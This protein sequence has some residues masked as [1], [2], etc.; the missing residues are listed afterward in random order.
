MK[1]IIGISVAVLAL[2][3]PSAV[4]QSAQSPSTPSDSEIRAIL[5]D[6]ID[7]QHAN[8]GIVVGIIGPTGRRVIAYG[9]MAK[10]DKRSPDGSTVF[11]I[12]S[13]TKV[14]TSLLLA[15]MAQ[16]GE[17][18]LA[19][20]VAK[21]L[22]V[23]VKAPE[24]AGKQI[25][26]QDLATHT[27]GLPKNPSNMPEKDPANPFADYSLDQLYQFLTTYQLTREIGVQYEYSSLGSGLL[28]NALARRAGMSY[29][30][31]LQARICAPLG[32]NDTRITLTPEMESRMAA[33]YNYKLKPVEKNWDMPALAGAGALR[34]TANDLLTFLAANLG[35]TKTSLAP[36]MA[37]MLLVRRH[38]GTPEMDSLLGWH[39]LKLNGREFIWHDGAT[40]GYTSFIGFDPVAGNGV[41]VLSNTQSTGGVLDIGEHLLNPDIPLHQQPKVIAV[42]PK[43][44]EGFVGSYRLSSN[45]TLT[46]TSDK[47]HL[48]LQ[49]AGL[50]KFEMAPVS[51][52]EY[53]LMGIDAHVT[54]GDEIQG[55]AGSATLHQIGISREAKRIE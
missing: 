51:S 35:N 5:I 30:K 23:G 7:T 8:V 32:M 12:G 54:F 6:R 24:Y 34:S 9:S 48:Y 25:T 39:S 33:G 3:L 37:A 29:E 42:D 27:S 43:L 20:P 21:Y 22:P 1:K 41:V 15:D 55:K 53:V 50:P 4:A 44:F 14:F 46:V 13:V 16:H 47:D 10:N 26:L 18:A 17:V 40:V 45:T 36:A 31:L 28:G 38:T 2:L 52:R 49:M 19:D 11:E